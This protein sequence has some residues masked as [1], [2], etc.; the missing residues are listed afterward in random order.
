MGS[1][2]DPAILALISTYTDRPDLL[3]AEVEKHTPGFTKRMTAAAENYAEKRRN[4]KYKFGMW[5]AYTGLSIQ[6]L[7]AVVTLFLLGATVFRE[8]TFLQ[9]I[10]LVIFYAVSQG[11]PS[12]FLKI[13]EACSR[14]IARFRGSDA[15]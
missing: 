15:S 2:G 12:G 9:M 5:Q 13:V 3:I 6:F 1:G 11:G 4:I 14:A 8:A 7:A 10:A